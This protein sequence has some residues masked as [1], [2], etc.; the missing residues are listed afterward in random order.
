M[1]H[2]KP[3]P[4]APTQRFVSV[5]R[6]RRKRREKNQRDS[7]FWRSVGTMGTVGWSVSVPTVIGVLVGRWL[8]GRLEGSEHVFAVF[9]LLVGVIAGSVLAW[10][11]IAE[12]M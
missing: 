11:S 10:R 12:R 9:F 8:D 7:T 1:T 3:K 4:E 2:E 5:L 6:Q